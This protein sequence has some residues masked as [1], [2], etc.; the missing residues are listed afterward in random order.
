MITADAAYQLLQTKPSADQQQLIRQVWNNGAMDKGKNKDILALALPLQNI[1]AS[2]EGLK[3]HLEQRSKPC[4]SMNAAFY[5]ACTQK[6]EDSNGQ[7]DSV[8]G[9]SRAPYDSKPKEPVDYSKL[10]PLYTPEDNKVRVWSFLKHKSKQMDKGP[11]AGKEFSFVLPESV[12]MRFFLRPANLEDNNLML[13][14]SKMEEI[15]SMHP[16]LLRLTGVNTDQA[17]KGFGLKIRQIQVLPR[18]FLANFLDCF[19]STLT[20]VYNANQVFANESKEIQAAREMGVE[21]VMTPN[22]CIREVISTTQLHRCP[23][24][25]KLES[26]AFIF[27]DEKSSD[28]QAASDNVDIV[29]MNSMNNDENMLEIVDSGL[30]VEM[31]TTLQI[32]A[33]VLMDAV[34]TTNLEKAI[35]LLEVCIAHGAVTCLVATKAGKTAMGQKQDTAVVYYMHVDWNEAL[36]LN[37][38]KMSKIADVVTE[39]PNCDKLRMCCQEGITHGDPAIQWYNP[40]TKVLRATKDGGLTQVWIVYELEVHKQQLIED[41]KDSKDLKDTASAVTFLMSG[42][43]GWFHRLRVFEVSEVE[44]NMGYFE[45]KDPKLLVKWELRPDAKEQVNGAPEKTSRKRK[46]FAEIDDDQDDSS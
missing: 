29:N 14:D 18:A 32:S 40:E 23:V 44:N 36:W 39:F 15:P 13:H 8:F 34:N 1:P 35:R 41:S 20:A 26:N 43:V 11:R 27:Q 21:T 2:A 37:R 38:I 12:V 28:K 7:R 5:I 42:G 24:H 6:L 9:W 30:L 33:Q 46:F 10:E 31:G 19:N 16:V 17:E 45:F 22:Y 25:L 4:E 3:K